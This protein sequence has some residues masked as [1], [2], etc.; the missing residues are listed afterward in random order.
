MIICLG[1]LNWND[2][3]DFDAL[4]ID[5]AVDLFYDCLH[6]AFKL[7]VSITGEKAS[8]FPHWYTQE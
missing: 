3:L 4:E 6:E 5:G 8:K 7:N 1:S 2:I